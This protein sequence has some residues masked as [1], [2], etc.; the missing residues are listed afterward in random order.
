MSFQNDLPIMS[1]DGKIVHAFNFEFETDNHP[2]LVWVLLFFLANIHCTPSLK[3]TLTLISHMLGIDK[4]SI[5]TR[6]NFSLYKYN[7]LVI[8][9]LFFTMTL[10]AFV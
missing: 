9:Y 8:N 2:V 7:V 6:T 3:K 1:E 4:L 10:A 5:V